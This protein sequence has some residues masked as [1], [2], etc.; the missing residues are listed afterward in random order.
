MHNDLQMTLQYLDTKYLKTAKKALVIALVSL[1]FVLVWN[2]SA[3][4]AVGDKWEEKCQTYNKAI[5]RVRNINKGKGK[6]V[7]INVGSQQKK[8]DDLCKPKN[9]PKNA[10]DETS[11]NKEI[12]KQ[13]NIINTKLEDAGYSPTR[14]DPADD[15]PKKPSTDGKG[16]PALSCDVNSD[17]NLYEKYVNPIITLLAGFVAIAVTI[18]II[19]GGIRYA[20]AGDDPQKIGAAKRQIQNAIIALLAFIFLYAAIQWLVPSA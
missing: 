14:P 18:G 17:C 5:D 12:Q 6:K 2:T 7:D 13:I 16:D 20:G 15:T 1:L 9:K 8:Y 10:R 11:T 19:S 3:S 4:A